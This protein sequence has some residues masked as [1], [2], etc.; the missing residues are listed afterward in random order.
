[1]TNEFDNVPVHTSE[2]L[3]KQEKGPRSKMAVVRDLI[4]ARKSHIAGLL[5][6]HMDPGRLARLAMLAIRKTPKLLDCTPESLVGAVIQ[7]AQLGLEPDGTLGQAY[8]VPYKTECTLQVGY[9]GMIEL[10]RRSGR[11]SKIAAHVVYKNDHFLCSYG[12]EEKLEHIPKLDGDRGEVLAV[13]AIATLLDGGHVFD[14]LAIEDV[15][16]ARQS[17][18]SRNIWNSY[19]NEMAKKTA[20]RRLFKYLPIS[21]EVAQAVALDEIGE[22][23]VSQKLG[24][25]LIDDEE[26]NDMPLQVEGTS[27]QIK[28]QPPEKPQNAPQSNKPVENKK[29]KAKG[30]KETEPAPAAPEEKIAPEPDD[31]IPFGTPDTAEEPPQRE[32]GKD[33]DGEDDPFALS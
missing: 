10:A 30:K 1:M 21:I 3:A 22:A 15:E 2:S 7:A 27:Q 20:I 4:T 13:Y 14:V 25:N 24:M 28:E 23:G 9:R 16:K 32:Y 29:T 12:L 6:E 33:I 5:P 19:W 8:L 26:L 17:S 11:V 31:D 18:Q